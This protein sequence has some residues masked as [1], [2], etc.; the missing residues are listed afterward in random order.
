LEYDIK[1]FWFGSSRIGNLPGNVSLAILALF[2]LFPL[3]SMAGYATGA[4]KSV[5]L[6][7]LF[8]CWYKRPL[9]DWEKRLFAGMTVVVVTAGLSLFGSQDLYGGVKELGKIGHFLFFIPAYLLL[10][11]RSILPLQAL[12]GG[13]IV[14]S[15]VF[16]V[17][18]YIQR[19]YTP[20]DIAD[21]LREGIPRAQG[22]IN[23]IP[24][25]HL[26]ALFVFLQV[27]AW[28]CFWRTPRVWL[29][30]IPISCSLFIVYASGTRGAFPFIPVAALFL[31]FAYRAKLGRTLVF[32]ILSALLFG[33][34]V[35]SIT[36]N[37]VSQMVSSGI[38]GII[39]AQQNSN[40]HTAWG[41]RVEMW[42]NSLLVFSQHPLLGTGLGDYSE[43]MKAIVESGFSHSKDSILYF[44]HSHS[45]Y[46]QA[47]AM[48]GGVG[49]IALVIG[50]FAVPAYF[51]HT[52]FR[53]ADS[54]WMRFAALGGAMTI[55]SFAMYGVTGAWT[56][57][58]GDTS[59]YL[60]LL[61]S[62]L[63]AVGPPDV[64]EADRRK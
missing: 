53:R 40:A 29:L 63:W 1:L 2:F 49:L 18:S 27:S 4:F 47:L 39:E 23:P 14:A 58:H 50:I 56:S 16:A 35:I 9:T 11:Q 64:N 20:I 19:Y 59:G 38:N 8:F 48:T 60:L 42:R 15:L 62:F 34:V 30:A 28:I 44:N 41:A 31:V 25:G 3:L 32:S 46:F 45:I 17:T 61:L 55:I 5:V 22:G 21:H 43:D 12:V 57:S 24:F 36:Q 37:P 54:P 7:A 13:V 26:A 33:M 10:R 52:A 6:I 51:F